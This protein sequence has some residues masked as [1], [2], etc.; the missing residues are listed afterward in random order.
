[1]TTFHPRARRNAFRRRDVRQ[2][3]RV[4]F[5]GNP[6][7]R[8]TPQGALTRPV[9]QLLQCL[10]KEVGLNIPDGFDFSEVERL[11]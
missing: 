2:Q 1:M 9:R 10:A 3:R 11:S 4:F 6:P 5:P 7:A 8:P